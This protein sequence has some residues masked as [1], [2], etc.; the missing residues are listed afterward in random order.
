MLGHTRNN[1]PGEVVHRVNVDIEGPVP[2][3]GIHFK[4]ATWNWTTRAV[5]EHVQPAK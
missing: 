2:I 1:S 3:L 5:D 4:Q